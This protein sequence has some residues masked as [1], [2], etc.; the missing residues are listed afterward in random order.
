[1][2]PARR[3]RSPPCAKA[4]T[5]AEARALGVPRVSEPGATVSGSWQT[6]DLASKLLID[7]G[8][9]KLLE[10]P[11]ST[12]PRYRPSQLFRA[13]RCDC[14]AK[15]EAPDLLFRGSAWSDSVGSSPPYLIPESL[16]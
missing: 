4:L 7:P 6:P 16:P 9:R 12:S 3:E 13:R 8:T 10:V 15:A 2:G 5:A 11:D 1:M 14:A